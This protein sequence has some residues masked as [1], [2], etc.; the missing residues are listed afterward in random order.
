MVNSSIEQDGKVCGSK[1]L[2]KINNCIANSKKYLLWKH[3]KDEYE[4]QKKFILV[5]KLIWLIKQKDVKSNFK[6]LGKCEDK[7]VE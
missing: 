4:R 3:N 2:E 6:A 5:V 7:L 1:H